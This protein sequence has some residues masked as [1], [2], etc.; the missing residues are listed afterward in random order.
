MTKW[1]FNRGLLEAYCP[2]CQ[3]KVQID[4][5]ELRHMVDV[6]IENH[7]RRRGPNMA[8]H[9]EIMPAVNASTVGFRH[10]GGLELIPEKFR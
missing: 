2:V 6:A 1:E 4:L 8:H 9:D 5:G 7:P 10:C 3:S